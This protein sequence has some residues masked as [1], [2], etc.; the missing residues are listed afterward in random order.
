MDA[1]IV[2]VDGTAVEKLSGWF[3][4]GTRMRWQESKTVGTRMYRQGGEII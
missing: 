3:L 1:F 4:L 2:I